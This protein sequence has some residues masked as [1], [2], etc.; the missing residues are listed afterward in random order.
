M[1]PGAGGIVGPGGSDAGRA[2]RGGSTIDDDS[3]G[4][5]PVTKER[6]EGNTAR[7]EEFKLNPAREKPASAV[8]RICGAKTWVSCKLATWL[9]SVA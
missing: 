9:R 7:G 2:G 3:S 5:S 6:P 1:V 4:P 8:F